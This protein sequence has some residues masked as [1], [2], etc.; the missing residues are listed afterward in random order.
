MFRCFLTVSASSVLV[1]TVDHS[2]HVYSDTTPCPA[3][4]MLYI[5]FAGGQIMC[6]GLITAA[7]AHWRKDATAPSSIL[8]NVSHEQ[9]GCL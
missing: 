5:V 4:Q 3:A 1:D 8:T 9:Q 6:A 7:A 2:F